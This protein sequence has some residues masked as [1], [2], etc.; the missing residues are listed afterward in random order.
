[1]FLNCQNGWQNLRL[2]TIVKIVC[3]PLKF[4]VPNYENLILTDLLAFRRGKGYM[5]V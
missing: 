1:M 2:P 5:Y 3:L 4:C